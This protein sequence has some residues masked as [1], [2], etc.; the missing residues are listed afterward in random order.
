MEGRL[1]KGPLGGLTNFRTRDNFHA[2]MV[3]SKR[4]KKEIMIMDRLNWVRKVALEM[5][6]NIMAGIAK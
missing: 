4:E 2:T 3:I 6:L 5:E 1:N